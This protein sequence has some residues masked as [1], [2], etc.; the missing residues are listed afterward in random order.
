MGQ[1]VV[2]DVIAPYVY[3]GRLT[4]QDDRYV[5]LENVDVHDLRDSNTNRELYVLESRHHG[6][7][8]NR[9]R[10]LV[11]RGQIVSLS[12]LQDVDS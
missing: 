11:A 9:R 2:I 1:E 12:A 7:R 3:I 8:A 4:A 10:T 5:V 6:V